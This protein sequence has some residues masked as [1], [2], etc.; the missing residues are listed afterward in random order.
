MTGRGH[1]LAS[2]N[3]RD[4]FPFST[5]SLPVENLDPPEILHVDDSLPKTKI[6]IQFHNRK[7]ETVEFNLSHTIRDIRAYVDRYAISSFA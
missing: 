1:S 5:L 7:K 3:N 6:R 4:L 2:G